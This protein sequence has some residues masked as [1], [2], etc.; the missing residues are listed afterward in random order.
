VI[1]AF[2]PIVSRLD[3]VPNWGLVFRKTSNGNL[4]AFGLTQDTFGPMRF[5]LYNFNSPTSFSSTPYGREDCFFMGDFYWL[6]IED[7]NTNLLFSISYDGIEWLLIK[8]L[9]RTSFMT[10]G[11][12]E[13][14]FYGNNA[15]ST[16]NTFKLRLAH[17]SGRRRFFSW[18]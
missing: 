13:I 2:Q 16:S 15:A 5:T 14:G 10:G 3:G 12:N 8:S 4:H 9:G 1:A 18:A 11:P 7:N 17:R 6:K